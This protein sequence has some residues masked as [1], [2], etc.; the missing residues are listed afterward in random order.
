MNARS[1]YFKGREPNLSDFE[2]FCK[3][4]RLDQSDIINSLIDKFLKENECQ[5]TLDAYPK[6]QDPAGRVFEYAALVGAKSELARVLELMESNPD[7]KESFQVDMLRA[8]KIAEPIF[9][10]TRDP[11]LSKLLE[12]AEVVLRQ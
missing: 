5:Q 1:K 8:L 2:L 9:H 10:R 3:A 6:R 11:R 12:R 4:H 7:I